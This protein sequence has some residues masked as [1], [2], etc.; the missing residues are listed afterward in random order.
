M[1]GRGSGTD[2]LDDDGNGIVETIAT[3]SPGCTVAA[4]RM[5]VLDSR[6]LRRIVRPLPCPPTPPPPPPPSTSSAPAS[7]FS[8]S[9]ERRRRC[10]SDRRRRR[11]NIRPTLTFLEITSPFAGYVL[12]DVHGYPLVLPGSP[13]TFANIV[14]EGDEVDDDDVIDDDDGDTVAPAADAGRRRRRRTH[15]RNWMWRVTCYPDGA[16][17]RSGPELSSDL[18]ATLPYGSVIR[19]TRKV[20]NRMGLNRLGIETA[21]TPSVA[22]GGGGR[23]AVVVGEF[24]SQY[25]NPLSGQRGCVARPVPFPLPVLYEVTHPGGVDVH[26]GL[27]LSTARIGRASHGTVLSIVGRGFTDHPGDDCAERLKLAG[28]GGWISSR[29]GGGGGAREE[30]AE[31]LV[32]MVSIDASFDPD[33]PG[34]FHLNSTRRVMEELSMVRANDDVGE[35]T[36]S[37][38]IGGGGSGSVGVNDDTNNETTMTTGHSDAINAELLEIV[39]EEPLREQQSTVSI[40]G[41]C[42]AASTALLSL[43]LKSSHSVSG[44][45]TGAVA[46]TLSRSSIGLYGGGA[47]LSSGLLLSSSSSSGR[48][49][50]KYNTMDAIRGSSSVFP[51][52]RRPSVDLNNRCL[53]CLSDERTSTIV[54]GETGHIACCLACARILKAR[55]DNVSLK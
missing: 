29:G 12:S 10:A 40:A 50:A 27:E 54:H 39:G 38:G 34:R 4:I 30:D 45:F 11:S 33:D 5:H 26:S 28:G 32:R 31:L 8:S 51:D 46:P 2:Y 37:I 22:G 41:G 19:V 15:R 55:G 18:S 20:V 43:S 7:S 36:T 13:E 25:L 44:G 14:A 48:Q 52:G 23:T 1:G 47:L 42:D 16:L 21:T 3:L 6:T 49:A 9:G 53:I 17:V 35:T 24:V